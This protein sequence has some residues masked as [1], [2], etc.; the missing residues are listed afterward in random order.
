MK[1]SNNGHDGKLATAENT[2]AQQASLPVTNVH[3]TI[4]ND[5]TLVQSPTGMLSI[6]LYCASNATNT[7]LANV[8]LASKSTTEQ[9]G[10]AQPKPSQTIPNSNSS[11]DLQ[12]HLQPS[13]GASS[14]VS[15]PASATNLSP[16]HGQLLHDQASLAVVGDGSTDQPINLV[17]RIRN[18]RR[19][20]NDIRFEFTIDRG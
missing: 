12:Q 9:N 19:E 8:M 4:T 7:C 5:S 20:L 17:L 14:G 10:A 6:I 1:S 3:H 2:S 18:S 13:S 16:A 11:N 15:S